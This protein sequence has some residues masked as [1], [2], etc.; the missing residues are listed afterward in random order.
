MYLCILFNKILYEIIQ[1]IA[2]IANTNRKESQ[3]D[4]DYVIL[5]TCYQ[6]G[7]F[8]SRSSVSII[9]LPYFGTMTFLQFINVIIW[10]FQAEYNILHYESLEYILMIYVGLL[11]GAMYVNVAYNILSD[12]TINEKDREL[13]VNLMALAVNVGITMSSVVELIMDNTFFESLVNKSSSGSSSGT[14][15]STL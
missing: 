4:F 3:Q 2:Q 7:V 1:K 12:K 15:C 6:F 8:L 11:G 9:E 5:S 13:C 14:G 10:C